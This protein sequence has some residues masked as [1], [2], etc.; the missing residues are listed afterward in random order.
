MNDAVYPWQR[1]QWSAWLATMAGGRVPNALLL[2]GTAGGGIERFGASLCRSLLCERG[3]D[4]ACGTCNSCRLLTSENHPDY[5]VLTP[6]KTE[7]KVSQIRALGDFFSL[8]PHYGRY[9]V[10]FLPEADALNHAAA[11]ALLKT[12]EEPPPGGVIVMACQRLARLPATIRSRCRKIRFPL[13]GDAAV[14]WLAAELSIEEKQARRRLALFGMRP[15]DAARKA[16]AGLDREQ[17]HDELAQWLDG[18]LALAQ[19]VE[20]WGE[21]P[22]PVIQ[23]W[24][25]EELQQ[26]AREHCNAPAANP[27]FDVLQRLHARQSERCRLAREN[28]NPRLLLESGMLEWQKA[29]GL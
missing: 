6:E 14:A 11:N 24:L 21:Q 9:R 15:L 13:P 23:Q 4:G 8:N 5:L 29:F 18:K 20:Q 27:S 3:K 12:L 19:A 28:L 2:N 10:A 17:F 1:E 25:L 26:L 16:G 22:G 7:I